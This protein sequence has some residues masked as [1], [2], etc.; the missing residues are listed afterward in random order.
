MVQSAPHIYLS[1]LPFTPTNS[2]ISG[3]TSSEF[4]NVFSVDV[5]RLVDWP[6]ID[7]TFEGHEGVVFSVAYSPDGGKIVSSSGD[8]TVLVWDAETGDVLSGPFEGHTRAVSSVAYS[9]DGKRIVSGSYDQTLRVWDAETGG[10]L[11]EPFEGHTD[12][13]WS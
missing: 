9:P 4:P 1:A 5:G 10:V 13:V 6:S 12:T 2:I 11:A 8:R 3:L 7:V